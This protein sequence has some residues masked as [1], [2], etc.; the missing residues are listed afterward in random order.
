ML[1]D[2]TVLATSV[3]GAPPFMHIRYMLYTT[4]PSIIAT[5]TVFNIV[6]FSRGTA[7]VSQIATFS[8]A[9]KSLFHI[10]FWLMIIPTVTKIMIARKTP[11]IVMFLVSSILTGIFTLIFQ[12]NALLETSGIADGGII[13]C[14]RGLPV[15]FYDST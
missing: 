6:R 4:I 7:G 1:P 2:T 10:T 8:E 9:L 14:I 5:L 3:T 12:L 15:T 11:S 13:A